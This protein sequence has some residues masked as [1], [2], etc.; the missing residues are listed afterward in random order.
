M[1]TKATAKLS[2]AAAPIA[3]GTLPRAAQI[4]CPV[5]RIDP[6]DRNKLAKVCFA[7]RRSYSK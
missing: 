1:R 7:A 4:Y 5:G 3:I 2:R 6:V